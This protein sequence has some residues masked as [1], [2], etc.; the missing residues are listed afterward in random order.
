V[1]GIRAFSFYGAFQTT[2]DGKFGL[3]LSKSTE[4]EQFEG[5]L[6]FWGSLLLL[7]SKMPETPAPRLAFPPTSLHLPSVSS[8][9]PLPLPRL[10][11]LHKVYA[12]FTQDLRRGY[13][14]FT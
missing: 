9:S 6:D 13:A 10:S 14:E 1:T 7:L 12:G 8:D 5:V 3:M 4:P 2:Q 11:G